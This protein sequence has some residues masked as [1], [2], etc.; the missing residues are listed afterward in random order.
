MFFVSGIAE[1]HTR[2]GSQPWSPPYNPQSIFSPNQQ[3]SI[4]QNHFNYPSENLFSKWKNQD[5]QYNGFNQRN[6]SSNL[7]PSTQQSQ[8]QQHFTDL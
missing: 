8:Q 6:I 1:S 3:Q 5:Y 2:S 4:S 7:Y